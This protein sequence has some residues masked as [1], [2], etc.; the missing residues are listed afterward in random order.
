MSVYSNSVHHLKNELLYIQPVFITL[1]PKDKIWQISA[2]SPSL[3]YTGVSGEPAKS[4]S[5]QI[6]QIKVI[7][8]LSF[9]R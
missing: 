4:A 1:I 7:S 5:H 9:A 6:S 2:N 3:Q 8:G